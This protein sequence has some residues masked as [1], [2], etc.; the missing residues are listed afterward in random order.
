MI[1]DTFNMREAPRTSKTDLS[2]LE[3]YIEEPYY[4]LLER[5]PP[6]LAKI[7]LMHVQACGM[8]TSETKEYLSKIIEMR[9][10]AVTETEI[11]DEMLREY[12]SDPIAVQEMMHDIETCVFASESIGSGQTAQV[13]KHT[14][15]TKDGSIP[16]AIKYLL[17]PGVGTISASAEHD[18]VR[19]VDRISTIESQTAGRFKFMKVPHPY[20]RHKNRNTQCYGMELIDGITLKKA[21]D[22]EMSPTIAHELQNVFQNVKAE[23]IYAELESFFKTIHSYCLHGDIKPANIMVDRNGCFFIIDFGQSTL[24]QTIPEEG[25]DQLDDLKE[26]EFGKAKLAIQFFL[27]KLSQS[28]HP[29]A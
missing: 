2:Y 1:L 11:S 22:D 13:K 7:H 3:D 25:R 20:F 18:I 5:L 27:K 12:L 28:S 6:E 29:V 9:D 15:N 14:L 8:D 10:R 21:L 19:E 26:D 4:S 16:L 17:T 24:I 23:V